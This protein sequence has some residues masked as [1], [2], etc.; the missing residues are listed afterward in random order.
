[1]CYTILSLFSKKA[2]HYLNP[3][4]GG[5]DQQEIY[6][7]IIGVILT[8]IKIKAGFSIYYAIGIS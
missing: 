4:M 1:M 5:G 3:N 7:L 8:D 6:K 2:L